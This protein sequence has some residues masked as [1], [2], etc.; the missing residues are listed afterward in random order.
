MDLDDCYKKGLIK[1]TN[2]NP[3][4]I[5]SLLEMS[6]IDESTVNSAIL[7]EK[8]ISPYV[9]MAYD[10][11]RETL[12]AICVSKEYKVLSH[13]C[14]GELLK[15]LIE[16]FDFNEFDRIRYIRNS[17]K[18]YGNKVEFNQGKKIIKKIFNMKKNLYEKYLKN[19]ISLK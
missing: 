2:I 7:D 13:I 14:I 17:I 16:D 8:N 11:L 3:E 10:S 19:Q 6:K 15:T 1:K 9:S 4:L 5:K 18:Y 12:E